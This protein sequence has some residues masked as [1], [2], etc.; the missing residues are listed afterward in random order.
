MCG[1]R[2]ISLVPSLRRASTDALIYPDLLMILC[3]LTL[4]EAKNTKIKGLSNF[5]SCVVL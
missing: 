1:S 3:Y 4:P 2:E 5:L